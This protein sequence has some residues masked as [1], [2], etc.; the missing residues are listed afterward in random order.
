MQFLYNGVSCETRKPPC[1]QPCRQVQY[2]V[3]FVGANNLPRPNAA[4]RRNNLHKKIIRRILNRATSGRLRI[5]AFFIREFDIVQLWV[6]N[7]YKLPEPM[8]KFCP[9]GIS[10][11]ARA[12]NY[13]L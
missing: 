10:G 2:Q 7:E 1:S 13:L 4:T 8:G 9:Y 6:P 3:Q 5:F 12:A 11:N